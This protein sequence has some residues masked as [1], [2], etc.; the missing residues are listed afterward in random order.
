VGAT[1]PGYDV[2]IGTGTSRIDP[3]AGTL[4]PNYGTY[5]YRRP[6]SPD[7]MPGDLPRFVLDDPAEQTDA[8]ADS[9]PS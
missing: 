5:L 6:M 7:L 2:R 3:A 1:I 9:A 4:T 8:T